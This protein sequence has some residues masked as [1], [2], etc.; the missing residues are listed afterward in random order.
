MLSETPGCRIILA[1]NALPVLPAPKMK[2]SARTQNS[3]FSGLRGRF[4]A[5]TLHLAKLMYH[6]LIWR[7]STGRFAKP[8]PGGPQFPLNYEPA[9]GSNHLLSY[10]VKLLP[11]DWQGVYNH[12]VYFLETFV[13]TELFKGTCYKAANW[14][15]LGLTTGR[16]KNDHT[17][18]P[19]RSIKAVWG[20]PL[21]KNFRNLLQFE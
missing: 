4:K 5:Y 1:F 8:Y 18:K 17:K 14:R 13:D 9:P 2:G 16:G 10:I 6:Q 20:Y 11:N 21:C 3:L 12:P 15:Y 7:Y 19:N